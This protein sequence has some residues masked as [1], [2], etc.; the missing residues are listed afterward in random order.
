MTLMIDPVKW[1]EMIR[2]GGMSK[3]MPSPLGIPHRKSESHDQ[4]QIP[5]GQIH[6]FILIIN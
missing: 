5:R 2:L 6:I 4:A 3:Y 1:N